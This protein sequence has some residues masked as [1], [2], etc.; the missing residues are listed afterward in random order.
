[1]VHTPLSDTTGSQENKVLP[2]F[3]SPI[4]LIFWIN[5]RQIDL[6]RPNCFMLFANVLYSNTKEFSLGHYTV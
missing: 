6:D 5:S 1:M 3:K 2:W 4:T